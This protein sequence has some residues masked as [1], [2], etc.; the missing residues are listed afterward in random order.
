MPYSQFTTIGKVKE[1][2]GIITVEGDR[3]FP[4]IPSIAISQTLTNYLAESVPLA[5]A[6]S[7]EKVRSE[8]IIAPILIEVRR[9]L[10]R[11]ISLFSGEE[12]NVDES[13]GLNGVCDFLISSSPE[14]MEIEAPVIVL[15]EAKKGDLKVGVGQCIAEMI[16]AQRFN[17]TKR[18]ASSPIYG[19]ITSGTQWR[20]MRLIGQTVEIDLEDYGL[21]PVEQI[22]GFFL[23]MAENTA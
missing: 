16:A 22:I 13:V 21:N 10:E 12:F 7:S 3:F 4:T 6:V 1:A 18:S 11:R 15:V 2:F 8:N 14:Q 9:L 17:Q 20:F 23:W 19:C 5:V